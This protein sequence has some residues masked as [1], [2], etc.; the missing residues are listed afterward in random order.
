MTVV[1]DREE[2]ILVAAMPRGETNQLRRLYQDADRSQEAFQASSASQYSNRP[3]ASLKNREDVTNFNWTVKFH[4]S[5]C[6]DP[7]SSD[8]Q[9]FGA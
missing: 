3:H 7:A 9:F 5:C 6:P 8:L 2:V 4:P 1:R